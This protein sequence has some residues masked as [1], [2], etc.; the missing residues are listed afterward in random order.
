MAQVTLA[1]ARQEVARRAT[2]F[3]QGTVTANGNL[4]TVT[5]INNLNYVDAY[6]A[7]TWLLATSGTNNDLLRRV[8]AFTAASQTLTLYQGLTASPAVNDTFDLYR[9]FNPFTDIKN[10]INRAINVGAPDFR[11]KHRD[12]LTATFNTTQYQFP[13]LMMDKGLVAIEYQ[14]YVAA[15]QSD[16]PFQKVSPDL[17]EIIESWDAANGRMNKTLQLKFNPETNKLIR[18]VFDTTLPNVATSTDA[19]HLDLPELEWLYTQSVAELWRIE[20][21]RSSGGAQQKALETAAKADAEADKMRRQLAPVTP[22]KP[23]ARTTFR[24]IPGRGP[25]VW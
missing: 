10:A 9:R 5:D 8:S 17:Y 23:L 20:S 1:V 18:F 2:E 13:A 22:P 11:E 4:T 16:W 6:W 14:W 19:I 15:N 25:G 21:L 3:V 7:E 24:T 12:V